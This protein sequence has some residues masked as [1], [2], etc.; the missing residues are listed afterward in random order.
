MASSEQDVV[1][2]VDLV[3]GDVVLDSKVD[4]VVF[5]RHSTSRRMNTQAFAFLVSTTFSLSLASRHIFFVG[6][7]LN[8]RQELPLFKH[9]CAH[10]SA[11]RIPNCSTKTASW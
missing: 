7:K 1:I 8:A 10:V 4:V 11:E 6:S 9:N 3:D 5:G 2:V